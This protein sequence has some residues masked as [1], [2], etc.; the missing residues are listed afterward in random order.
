MSSACTWIVL[1]PVQY[2]QYTGTVLATAGTLFSKAD[3]EIYRKQRAYRFWIG[4]CNAHVQ[5]DEAT[6][7]LSLPT[8]FATVVELKS[9]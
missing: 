3:D 9:P 1:G 2:L 4:F 6:I 5:S 8:D 7:S